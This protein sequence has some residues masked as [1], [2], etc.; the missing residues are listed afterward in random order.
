MRRSKDRTSACACSARTSSPASTSRAMSCPSC[1]AAPGS[2]RCASSPSTSGCTR[3][4]HWSGSISSGC[5]RRTGLAVAFLRPA[6]RSAKRLRSSSSGRSRRGL[7]SGSRGLRRTTRR[8]ASLSAGRGIAMTAAHLEAVLPRAR[9]QLGAADRERLEQLNSL[10]EGDRL[11]L[12]RVLDALYPGRS[13]QA[14]QGY[15]QLKPG[16]A[17]LSG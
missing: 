1:S 5:R 9:E 11:R 4:N 17:R 3:R 6:A 7:R 16:P 8:M 10:F 15:C 12:S 14:Q 2:S 13:R